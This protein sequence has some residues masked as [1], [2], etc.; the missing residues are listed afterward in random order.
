LIGVL[1]L[2]NVVRI[3][4]VADAKMAGFV[5][6]DI[7]QAENMAWVATIG[8]L[9][10]YRGRGIGRAL[11]EA[12]EARLPTAAVRLNVRISNRV[13]ID[14]YRSAGYS[15]VGSWPAYYQDG[16]DAMVMEKIR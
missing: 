15:E 7:H 1:T 14:L 13:A 9:P 11:L 6:G 2:P 12:C 5:A 3:K 8:V 10:E 4:A 16:E